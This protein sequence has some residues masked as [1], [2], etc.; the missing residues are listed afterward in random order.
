MV[1]QEMRLPDAPSGN[2]PRQC[3]VWKYSLDGHPRPKWNSN[4]TYMVT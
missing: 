3:G 2:N 1:G 4:K